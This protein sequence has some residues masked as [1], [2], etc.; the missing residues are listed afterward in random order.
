[1]T[2]YF[3][4]QRSW[5][6]LCVLL[7]SFG[8][9]AT[10]Q[11]QAQDAP[12][13]PPP[14]PPPCEQKHSGEEELFKV[15]E[16]MPR[17]PGCEEV[18]N[19]AERTQCSRK[20]LLEYVYQNVRYPEIARTSGVQGTVVVQFVVDKTGHIRDAKIIREIG[21]GC[22]D[23]A[24]R[25]VNSMSEAGITWIPGK[26]RGIPVSVQ[27]TLPIKFKLDEGTTGEAEENKAPGACDFK[28][29]QLRL[30]D[31]EPV[32]NVAE[33]MPRY[34]G[35]EQMTDA[36]ERERC[37]QK[38]LLMF[39]Y[40]NIK[41][42]AEARENNVQGVVVVDFVVD[43]EG[44]V[45]EPKIIRDIGGGCS[46]EVL[47]LVAQMPKWI[48]GKQGGKAVNVSFKL[49]VKFK[50]SGETPKDKPAL[51][52]DTPDRPRLSPATLTPNPASDV[53]RVQWS[54]A[55]AAL[56][57]QLLSSTGQV[58]RQQSFDDFSGE[59]DHELKL[60]GLSSGT[61]YVVLQQGEAVSRQAVVVQQAR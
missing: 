59:L 41:Y 10:A 40:Q 2:R 27:F 50:L 56:Q 51:K 1:M 4:L 36:E 6:W 7:L 44:V 9:L 48:P 49:P 61:Y 60:N 39:V 20:K 45:R 55:A 32:L 38:E 54:G 42:P 52:L 22:G 14:P 29:P 26:Q 30:L 35:C 34:P 57:L 15:V 19:K 37:A 58:V 28:K 47:E 18:E 17:F 5:C 46:E 24:L 13:P 33:E 31:G 25:V 53:V 12:P 16:E 8:F 21:A 11:L 23:E 3:T 43:K